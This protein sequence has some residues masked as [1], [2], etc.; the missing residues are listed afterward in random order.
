MSERKL[1]RLYRVSCKNQEGWEVYVSHP[2]SYRIA[3][4]LASEEAAKG[5]SVRIDEA[6]DFVGT[7]NDEWRNKR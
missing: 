5:Y 4:I 7:T 1:K 3:T 2:I 6:E